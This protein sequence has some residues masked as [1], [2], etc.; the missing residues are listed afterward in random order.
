MTVFSN[1]S[2]RSHSVS[3]VCSAK[4][5]EIV[6]DI[7]DPT[8]QDQG[9]DEVNTQRWTDN[10]DYRFT[11]GHPLGNILLK[12]LQDTTNLA[13]KNNTKSMA[14][15]IEELCS[16]FSNGIRLER[17]KLGNKV[18]NSLADVERNIIEKELNNHSINASVV[19]PSVFSNIP[20]IT[21]S[22]KLLEVQKI[23]PKPGRFSGKIN[24]E[25]HISVVEFLNSLSTAQ[26]QLVLS[27]EEFIDRILTSCTGLA[28]DLVLEWKSNGDNASII[29]HSLMVNFDDR[30]SPEEARLKLNN[31]VVRRNSNLA[32]AESEIQLL[33]GRAASLIPPGD[34]RNAYRNMEGCTTLIRALPPYSSLTANNLYQSFTTRMGR[35]CTM[36]ELFRGIDQ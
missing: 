16:S 33:V 2:S 12:I 14:T 28:H 7:P 17:A 15:N 13:R 22:Q 29:Y 34:A 35:S 5:D 9:T 32:K 18:E 30:M 11:A 20:V 27:E 23:F 1:R 24:K 19:P 26:K 8:Q 10:A 36:H 31:F 21:S 4:D 6:P 25:G 3:C